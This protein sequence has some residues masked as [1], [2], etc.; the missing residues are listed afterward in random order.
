MYV[1]HT[2]ASTFFSHPIHSLGDFRLEWEVNF[3]L[4]G[5]VYNSHNFNGFETM[6]KVLVGVPPPQSRPILFI[7]KIALILQ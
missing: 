5:D 2:R 7:T 4:K 1:C 6:L 3:L